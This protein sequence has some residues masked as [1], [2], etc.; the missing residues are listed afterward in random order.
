[1]SVCEGNI[2]NLVF[3]LV[4]VYMKKVLTVL[5][6]VA[7]LTTVS[8]A[9]VIDSFVNADFDSG[10]VSNPFKGFDAPGAPEI[11]GW[12]NYPA[13]ALNDA[14]VEGSG[15]WWGTYQNNSAFMSNPNDA[16]YNLSSYVIKA[17]DAFTVSFYGKGDRK[18]VV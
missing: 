1:M 16:A 12:T 18:S 17:G 14:G 3:N 15:A 10:A 9:A 2:L 8:Q 6:I 11:I 4:E 13:G 7:L 5:L